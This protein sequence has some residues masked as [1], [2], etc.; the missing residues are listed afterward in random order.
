MNDSKQIFTSQYGFRSGHSCQEVISELVGEIARNNDIGCHT[1]GVF[2]D[3]SK[4]FDTL[5]HE[6]LF[7]K[8]YKYGIRGTPLNWY[9]SYLTQRKLR[10]KYMVSST[11]RQEYSQYKD[12]EFGTPQGSCLGPLLFLV[13]INDLHRNLDYCN[14]IPFADDTTIYKGH[15]NMRYLKCCIEMDLKNISEWFKANKLTLNITKSVYMIFSKKD[16]KDLD[17]TL[18][19]M[20]LPRVV[21]S[22]NF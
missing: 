4:A 2:L 12:V 16:Q 19:D 9:R 18:G 13:F 10:V 20:K 8:L 21:N 7:E 3:L 11:Q 22:L 14:D 15:R 1:I 5:E 17:I 6:V